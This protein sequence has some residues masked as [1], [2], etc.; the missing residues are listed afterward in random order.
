[1]NFNTTLFFFFTSLQF[2]VVLLAIMASAMALFLFPSHSTEIAISCALVFGAITYANLEIYTETNKKE[3]DPEKMATIST[4]CGWIWTG[5]LA[6]LQF[7]RLI[8]G[9]FDMPQTIKCLILI[10]HV[11]ATYIPILNDKVTLCHMTLLSFIYFSIVPTSDSQEESFV[12]KAVLYILLYSIVD[13]EGIIN[14]KL[15]AQK[16]KSITP[17]YVFSKEVGNVAR[18]V[19]TSVE[20]QIIRSAWILFAPNWGSAVAI[21]QIFFV[22]FRSKSKVNAQKKSILPFTATRDPV[23][24]TSHVKTGPKSRKKKLPQNNNNSVTLSKAIGKWL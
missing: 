10:F 5:W 17:I 6:Y 21:A 2:I 1:M 23:P 7:T 9:M 11:L 19:L 18:E 13:L 15:L 12:S 22:I 8:P 16:R 14:E 20:L 24:K 4:T 3:D